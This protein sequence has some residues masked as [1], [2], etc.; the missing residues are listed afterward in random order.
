MIQ[1]HTDFESYD[2]IKHPSFDAYL[3]QRIE[4]G[5]K[6]RVTFKDK[7]ELS[8]IGFLRYSPFGSTNIFPHLLHHD[9]KVEVILSHDKVELVK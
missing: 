8:F 9:G 2:E 1:L 5:Q 4:E 6:I 3:W 7:P